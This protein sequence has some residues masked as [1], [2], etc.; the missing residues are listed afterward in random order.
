MAGDKD[1]ATVALQVLIRDALRRHDYAEA[2]AE[3]EKMRPYTKGNASVGEL[4]E[5]I[6]KANEQGIE[7]IQIGGISTG[8]R[9]EYL[10]GVSADG[11]RLYFC[12]RDRDDNLGGEDV[13]VTERDKT[14]LE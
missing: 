5:H 12:G 4:L 2:K 6:G 13:Y 8:Q 7:T 10:P 11:K 14:E 9:N 3:I 1:Q